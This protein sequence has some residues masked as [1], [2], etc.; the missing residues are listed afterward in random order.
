M[1]FDN[2]EFHEIANAFPMMSDTELADLAKDIAERGLL[3]PIVLFEGKILDGRNRD[4]GRKRAGYH[5]SPEEGLR[6]L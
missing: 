4:D 2:L 3:E 6:F 1:N 5:L